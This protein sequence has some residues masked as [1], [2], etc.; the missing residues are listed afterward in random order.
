MPQKLEGSCHCGSVKFTCDSYAPVA[1]Q[2]CMC[3]M[4]R[5]CGGYGGSVNLGAYA[6]SLKIEGEEH[7]KKYQ[8][9]KY[10]ENG[11][12]DGRHNSQRSFCG[13]CSTMLWLFDDQWPE[14][15]H[16][17]ASAIDTKLVDPSKLPTPQ[18]FVVVRLDS[19]PEYVRLPEGEK[20][21]YQVYGP[22]SLEEWH[23][24]AGAFPE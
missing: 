13:N 14:L 17:F 1:Y 16:P 5:K 15:I 21:L 3:S 8:A 19:K 24:A 9:V 7:I 2:L 6:E 4:C 23:K 12:P 18:P 10:D 11:K 20:E 22:L